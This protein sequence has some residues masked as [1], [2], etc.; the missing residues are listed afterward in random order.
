MNCVTPAKESHA[1]KL[2][3]LMKKRQEECKKPYKLS[4]IARL[5]K[6]GIKTARDVITQVRNDGHVVNCEGSGER[7]NPCYWLDE[8]EAHRF[9]MRNEPFA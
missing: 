3:G 2:Y 7:G 9:Q 5:L 8:A 4:Q 1:M 6:V